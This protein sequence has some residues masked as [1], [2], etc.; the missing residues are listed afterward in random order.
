MS[1][2]TP[3][4]EIVAGLTHK[5]V[6]FI[7]TWGSGDFLAAISS[8]PE[9]ERREIVDELFQR[10]EAQVRT[11]PTRHRI[12]YPFAHMMLQKIIE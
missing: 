12:D 4:P 2:C 1:K 8:R 10:L 5:F 3:D 9:T 6:M 11:E 7:R